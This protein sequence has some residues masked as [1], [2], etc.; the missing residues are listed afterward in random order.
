MSLSENISSKLLGKMGPFK[1]FLCLLG[2]GLLIIFLLLP[3]FSEYQ[4]MT[5]ETMNRIK[6]ADSQAGDR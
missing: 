5:D 3:N 4:N 2:V 6:T 1:L